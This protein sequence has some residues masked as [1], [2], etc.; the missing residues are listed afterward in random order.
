MIIFWGLIGSLTVVTFLGLGAILNMA[1][2]NWYLSSIVYSIAF[3]VVAS[4]YHSR[5]SGSI[6]TVLI[7]GW[8]ASV[9]ASFIVRILKQHRYA[10]FG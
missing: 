6:W 4:L 7:L 5:I 8:F 3:L 10:M 2:R 9:G 1:F